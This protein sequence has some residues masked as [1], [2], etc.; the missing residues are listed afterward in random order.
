MKLA[1]PLDWD[2][3]TGWWIVWAVM[4]FVGEI[5]GARQGEMLSHH[6]WWLRNNGGSIVF[7]LILGILMWLNYHFIIEGWRVFR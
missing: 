3:M 2:F 7:F 5:I 4:F 1:N 6:I